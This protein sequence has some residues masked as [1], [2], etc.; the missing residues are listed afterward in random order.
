MVGASFDHAMGFVAAALL[1]WLLAAIDYEAEHPVSGE[2]EKVTVADAEAARAALA[3]VG[4]GG[5]DGARVDDVI[6]ATAE[7]AYH[8]KTNA[9]AIWAA[10]RLGPD[11]GALDA[12]GAVRSGAGSLRLA[13]RSPFSIGGH[14]L[15]L[16]ASLGV[17]LFP[18]DGP[19][20]E[21]LLQSASVALKRAK[22]RGGDSWDVHAP[23]SQA[24]AAQ[25]QAKE[26]A[27]RRALVEKALETVMQGRR[28]IRRILR[29]QDRRLLVVVG[30]CSVHDPVAAMEYAFI[31]LIEGHE[32]AA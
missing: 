10:L 5:P 8:E 9:T 21:S 11:T 26:G 31:A 2:L 19:S 13:L 15:H 16:T 28:Q 3:P 30:P 23:R 25:R 1:S 29:K 6:F 24:L 32:A 17:A 4:G 7:P 27:L 22:S 14:D 18:D 20:V 12:T